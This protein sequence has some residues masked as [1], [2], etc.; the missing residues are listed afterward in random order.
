MPSD[1]N[2]GMFSKIMVFVASKWYQLQN[3]FKAKK[4]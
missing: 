3:L 1:P 2:G 4:P